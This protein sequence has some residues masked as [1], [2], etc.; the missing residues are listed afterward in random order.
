MNAKY[1]AAIVKNFLG[2]FKRIF[3][4]VNKFS[5]KRERVKKTDKLVICR[6][7]KFLFDYAARKTSSATCNM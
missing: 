5:W 3:D 6:F 1:H 4:G 2:N 7:G